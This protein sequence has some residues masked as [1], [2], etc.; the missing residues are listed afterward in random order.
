MT[1]ATLTIHTRYASGTNHARCNGH[2]A[3][4]TASA[5]S[6]ARA[7]AHKAAAAMKTLGIISRPANE[8][9][10]TEVGPGIYQTEAGPE[11]HK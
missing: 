5:E 11:A 8:F 9:P 10:L 3:T 2:T 1:C 6:A 7:V 4:C